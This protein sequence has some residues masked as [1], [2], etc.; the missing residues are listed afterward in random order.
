MIVE[1][2]VNCDEDGVYCVLKSYIFEVFEMCI[3]LSVDS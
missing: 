1:V 3:K 2:I